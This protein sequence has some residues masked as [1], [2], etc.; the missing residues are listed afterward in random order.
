MTVNEALIQH[1]ANLARLDFDAAAA[2]AMQQDLEKIIGF[3]DKLN[4]LDTTGVAPL[5]FMGE[6]SNIY[7][8]DVPGS[9]LPVEE[10]LQNA[11][12][13]DE[14]FFKVPKVIKRD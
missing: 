5:R 7:R 14:H 1:L 2:T 4:A 10:A 6:S 8:P 9:N 13:K 11:P 12:H 3:V